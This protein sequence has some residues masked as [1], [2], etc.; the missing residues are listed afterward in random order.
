MQDARNEKIGKR[1]RVGLFLIRCLI[2]SR[3]E[4]PPQWIIRTGL[5]RKALILSK[6]AFTGTCGKRNV[7]QLAY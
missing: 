5:Q 7:S 4:P 2:N 1:K 3:K 6:A